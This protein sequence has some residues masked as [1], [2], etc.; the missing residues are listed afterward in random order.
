MKKSIEKMVKD[1]MSSWWKEEGA[2]ESVLDMEVSN[3][4][5]QE[6][7][8]NLY[9]MNMEMNMGE[10]MIIIEDTFYTVQKNV[11]EALAIAERAFY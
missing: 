8:E 3:I 4:D 7:D 9:G 6:I 11:R 2:L 5:E 1:Q 10:L